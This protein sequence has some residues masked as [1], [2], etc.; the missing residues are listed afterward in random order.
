MMHGCTCMGSL[1]RSC[2]IHPL[3]S[4]P[5]DHTELSRY[6]D[7]YEGGANPGFTF[8][9]YTSTADPYE[10]ADDQ[11]LR[12]KWL[13]DAQILSG[14]FRPSGRV[15]GQTNQAATELPTRSTLPQ[16]VAELR[17]SIEADWGEYAFLVCSTDDEHVVVRFELSTL[18]SEPGLG[19]YMNVFSRSHHVVSKYQLRKVVED[20]NVTPGDGHLYF[21]FRPPWVTSRIT[22]T[23]F[24]L[25]P[26]QRSYQDPRLKRRNA[27][28]RSAAG[29]TSSIG[30][31]ALSAFASATGSVAGGASG[32]VV[33][34]DLT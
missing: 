6:E 33:R 2:R 16:M 23:F 9:A 25:H 34:P 24:S 30:A 17:E 18:D 12:F 3:A 29:E 5:L 4:H 20:W 13:Q 19:A 15:K 11:S 7:S 14:P 28:A 1:P 22:D 26:E 21:T 8:N 27:A 31:A 10:R 32:E